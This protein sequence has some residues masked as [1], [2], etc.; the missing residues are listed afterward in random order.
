[1]ETDVSYCRL[2]D[3]QKVTDL[4][5]FRTNHEIFLVNYFERKI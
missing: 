1:M 3:C 4:K 5:Q 2:D